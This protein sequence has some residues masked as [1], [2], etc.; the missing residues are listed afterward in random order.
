MCPAGTPDWLWV[1]VAN[2]HG[3]VVALDS[4]MTMDSVVGMS[5]SNGSMVHVAD[6]EGS[7]GRLP[8]SLNSCV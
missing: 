5:V 7:V 4:R 2:L 8:V 6:D 3:S 1:M